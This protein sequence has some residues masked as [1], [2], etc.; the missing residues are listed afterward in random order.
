[1]KHIMF[2]SCWIAVASYCIVSIV[3][4]PSGLIEIR[5]ANSTTD[6]MRGNLGIL[7]EKN[8]N[9]TR[10]L[11]AL[12]TLPE[13]ISLEARSLGFI[14]NDETVI[15]IPSNPE[16]PPESP[17]AGEM[18]V[19]R[20]QPSMMDADVKKVSIFVTMV[21]TL[22]AFALRLLVSNKLPPDHRASLVHEASRT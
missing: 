8:A 4:G 6:L 3:A 22:A 20:R 9:F 14:A 18:V 15:R 2:F 13:S 7:A 10:E 11:D 17:A 21:A 16:S 1:M 12:H 19:Y 5:F